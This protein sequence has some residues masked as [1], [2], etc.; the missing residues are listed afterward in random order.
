MS[1]SV[2]T[3]QD[4]AKALDKIDARKGLG[5]EIYEIVSR[6]TPSVCVELI[7]K[8]PT[9]DRTLLLWREDTL[10]G[11][12]WHVPGGVVRFKELLLERVEKVLKTE[13]FATAKSIEGP[14][15]THEIF[16]HQRDIRGH[17]I[18]FVYKIELC[19]LPPEHLQAGINAKNGMWRWF[20]RCP[21]NLIKNQQTLRQYLP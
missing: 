1:D 3:V 20:E 11:P 6:L 16:N 19:T 4:L 18:S 14:I 17:F 5:K 15:G 10:Y 2:S 13:I 21:K 7:I 8:C 9:T 12:G